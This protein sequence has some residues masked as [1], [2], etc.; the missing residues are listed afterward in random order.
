MQTGSDPNGQSR[1]KE[2][3]SMQDQSTANKSSESSVT[4]IS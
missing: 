1:M 3:I 2:D 4:R